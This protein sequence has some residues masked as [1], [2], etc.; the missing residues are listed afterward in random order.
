MTV[1]SSDWNY[2]RSILLC[3]KCDFFFCFFVWYLPELVL[4]FLLG[5]CVL[6]MVYVKCGGGRDMYFLVDS[7]E[8]PLVLGLGLVVSPSEM[9]LLLVSPSEMIFLLIFLDLL[10]DLLCSLGW[11]CV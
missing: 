7:A 3:V 9:L 4:Y 10:P 2:V 8:S 1:F 5:T 6:L 11:C